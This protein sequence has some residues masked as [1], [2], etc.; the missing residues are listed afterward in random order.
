MFYCQHVLGIGH[1]VRSSEIVRALQRDFDVLFVSG[2]APV[3]GFPFPELARIEALPPLENDE[4]FSGLRATGAGSLEQIKEDRKRILLGLL[5]EHK[6]DVLVVELFPFG[7]KG[8]A[9]ELLP[10]L[11]RAHALGARIVSSVRDLLVRKPDQAKR[12]EWTLKIFDRYFDLLLVH[13][14]PRLI[15]FD[16]SFDSSPKLKGRLRYTGYVA[17]NGSRANPSLSAGSLSD[18]NPEEPRILV[19]VGGGRCE[20][21]YKII[22]TA[23]ASA[24]LD[25]CR[26]WKFEILAGPLAPDDV[27]ARMQGF[28]ANCPNVTLNRYVP[29]LGRRM[30]SAD[31]SVSMAGY[32]TLMNILST[33]ARA[34]VCPFT[35]NEDKEQEYRARKLESRGLLGVVEARDLE[36]NRLVESM[37]AHLRR[38]RSATAFDLSGAETTRVALLQLFRKRSAHRSG[39]LPAARDAALT[40]VAAS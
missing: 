4:D 32:N 25:P 27:Y 5:E 38:P 26:N 33:G 19:S 17:E 7:R 20:A 37:Q 9:F 16:E 14:D 1:L 40:T 31:L 18:A 10:L 3:H 24:R 15:S 13:G 36:P 29:D 12:E 30:A 6:P 2:G 22:E 21:G 23:M 28:A 11:E 39:P 8:F 34:L 35:G